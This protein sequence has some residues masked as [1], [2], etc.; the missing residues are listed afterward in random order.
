MFSHKNSSFG[1]HKGRSVCYNMP[2]PLC[3]GS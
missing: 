3:A 1:L 2:V